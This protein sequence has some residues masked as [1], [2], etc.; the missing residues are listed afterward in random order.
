MEKE[1]L[2]QNFVCVCVSEFWS[3]NFVFGKELLSYNRNFVFEKRIFG[4]IVCNQNFVFGKRI[5]VPEFCVCVSQN[6]WFF[7]KR[8]FFVTGILKR[9]VFLHVKSECFWSMY[10]N[11]RVFIKINIMKKLTSLQF[12]LCI[13]VGFFSHNGVHV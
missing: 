13:F 10:Q 3:K 8:T 5:F 12:S 11:L 9:K 1:F 7:G 6:F 4:L 2:S